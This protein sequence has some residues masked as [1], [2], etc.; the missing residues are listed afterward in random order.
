MSLLEAERVARAAGWENKIELVQEMARRPEIQFGANGYQC[1]HGK[2]VDAAA[3][4]AWKDAEQ[5]YES[6]ID[7]LLVAAGAQM[8]K[9][10][11]AEARVTCAEAV[12]LMDRYP[13]AGKPHWRLSEATQLDKD[14]QH[15][16]VSAEMT[17]KGMVLYNDKWMT[18]DQRFAEIQTARGLVKYNEKWMT[19]DEKMLAMGN[20]KVDGRWLTPAEKAALDKERAEAARLAAAERARQAELARL[21]EIEKQKQDAYIGCQSFV[22]G[23]LARPDSAKFPPYNDPG[24]SVDYSDGWYEVRATVEAS[25][26]WG[27][28]RSARFTVKLRRNANGS[29]EAESTKVAD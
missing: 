13:A 3:A 21:A 19:P 7:Q 20:V 14:A 29:W 5:Q 6:K 12:A 28:S 18:P 25:T 27:L 11:Y 10:Q 24:V 8:A 1:I 2:W 16:V 9:S 15:Q 4:L 22:K 23:Q 17:A 26:E